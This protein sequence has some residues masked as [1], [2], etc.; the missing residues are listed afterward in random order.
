MMD[1]NHLKAEVGDQ[2]PSLQLPAVGIKD[3]QRYADASGDHNPIHIDRAFAH[4]MGLP[5]VLAQGMLIMAYLGR[6]LT[7]AAPQSVLR[8]YGVRFAAPTA[9]G[10]TLTCEGIVTDIRELNGE[11]RLV[12]DLKVVGA[13]GNVKMT[14]Q[15][16]IAR[17]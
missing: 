12:I 15:A 14:G 4:G 7:D 5:D 6:L 16:E 17:A 2:L 13:A 10:E 3:F 11:T 8:E 9:A 1:W